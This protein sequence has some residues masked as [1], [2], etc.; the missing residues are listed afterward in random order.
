M[1]TAT[2]TS[3]AMLKVHIDQGRDYLDYLRPFVLQILADHKPDPVTDRLIHDHLRSQYGLEIPERAVQVV[4]K[5]LSR[6]C[7]LTK[8]EGVYRITGAMPDPDISAAK[9]DAE[10]H[11]NAVIADMQSFSRGTARPLPTSEAA[12]RALCE[13]LAEFDVQCL[14]AY[15]RGTAI[16]TIP[17][18]RASTLILVSKYVLQ[19]QHTNPERF[20]SFMILL[21]GHML[22]NA[23]LCPDLQNAPKTYRGMTFFFDTPLL[24]R[25]L[26]LEGEMQQG[27][28]RELIS[29][30]NK[31]GAS[32]VAFS[33]S[34]AELHHVITRSADFI[35]ATK[36]RGPIVMEARRRGTTKSDLVLIA[37]QIDELLHNASIQVQDSPPYTHQFQIDE[38]AFAEALEDE[39][40]YVNPR[41]K[42]YD[43]NSLRA[44]YVLRG[45]LAPST[46]EKAR[47]VLVT[48]NAA[49][50]RAAYQY[51]QTHERSPEVS[52]VITD[53]SL[54]NMAWLKAPLGAPSLPR[55]EVLAFA[56]AALQPTRSLLNKYLTEIEK[57]EERGGITHTD[58]QL[59]RSSVFA[60][61]EMMNLTLGS[62][63]ALT[64]EVVSE[65]LQ[66]VS[67][68]IRKDVNKK[69]AAEES[70]HGQTYAD[71][72]A[73]RRQANH[74]Q[75]RLY[76]KCRRYSKW[77]AGFVSA[78]IVLFLVAGLLVG[79]GFAI[80]SGVV[81]VLTLCN[82]VL[83]T[84]VRKL[85]RQ[86]QATCLTWFL[87][88]ETAATGLD[89]EDYQP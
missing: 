38:S 14:R 5:R 28:M 49:F 33:H 48:S 3:L 57:L 10:R 39:L 66:R 64:E 32:T 36:G 87:R 69:L 23:L 34:R 7:P 71:L 84:T 86:V 54:A 79:V 2:L 75:E 22:A 78:L 76:W 16:P 47:A 6:I 4:L 45:S 55:V 20:D 12:V 8:E 42:E 74:I 53:F 52:S 60:Q 35:D 82:L 9:S 73:A 50:A 40:F 21:Q 72:V 31:L 46:L 88:R 1:S 27:A 43:I 25:L 67:S 11:I 77:C 62:E 17:T 30:L 63:D 29:L 18:K 58:H 81:M 19:L 89:L 37:G 13:F 70:A 61:D 80:G 68:E 56:Y 41:A 83:G 24:I 44:I 85:H 51:G 15:L 26:G 65:T 59:L